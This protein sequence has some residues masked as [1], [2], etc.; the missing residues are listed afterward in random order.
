MTPSPLCTHSLCR[1]SG[2][3]TSSTTPFLSLVFVLF[4]HLTCTISSTLKFFIVYS[5]LYNSAPI[6]YFQRDPEVLFEVSIPPKLISGLP[7]FPSQ[8]RTGS[9]L[10]R[11]VF[12]SG[13]HPLVDV[14]GHTGLVPLVSPPVF[15]YFDPYSVPRPNT[16]RRSSDLPETTSV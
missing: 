13:L 6:L 3:D 16:I 14:S 1:M 4:I 11:S 10:I 12:F 2:T 7:S 5:L 15:L 9:L 8:V